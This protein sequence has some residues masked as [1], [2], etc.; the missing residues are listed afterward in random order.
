MFGSIDRHGNDCLV[1]DTCGHWITVGWIAPGVQNTREIYAP[2]EAFVSLF[3]MIQEVMSASD[4]KRPSWIACT[5]GPG[6]FTGVRIGVATARTLAMLWK[7]PLMGIDHL[8]YLLYSLNKQDRSKPLAIL[9]DAKQ[10]RVYAKWSLHPDHLDEMLGTEPLDTEVYPFLSGL[11]EDCLVYGDD[12]DT[13]SSYM[14]ESQ[15]E[16]YPG[17]IH[18]L[19]EPHAIYLYELA[20][21]LGGMEK[22]GEWESTL[23]LYLRS[24]P[25]HTKYPEGFNRKL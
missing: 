14:N 9:L 11:P 6:S 5:V 10:K 12:P 17:R 22:A 4:L 15:L 18:P 7:I 21:S 16:N 25:A 19:P 8:T 1:I 23:P 3:P 20:L 13:I 24:D 2:R